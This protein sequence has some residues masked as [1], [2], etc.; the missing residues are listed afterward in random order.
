MLTLLQAVNS[1]LRN[2]GTSAVTSTEVSN[3]DVQAALNMIDEKRLSVQ[4]TGWWF[5]T[6]NNITLPLNLVNECLVPSNTLK[7][8][9]KH[10]GLDVVQQGRKLFDRGNNTFKFDQP[11][12]IGELV[13]VVDWDNLPFTA[14]EVIKFAAMHQVQSDLEGDA[15]KLQ[16]IE[17]QLNGAYL[18]MKR[19]HVQNRDVNA[20][21]SKRASRLLGRRNRS[22]RSS[23]DFLGG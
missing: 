6:Q 19:E 8:D 1:I 22:N 3:P 15:Q 21:T 4:S 9:T 12:V 13:V 16:Q 7:I 17:G 11:I 14:R 5:N 23:G 20:F 10:D 18:A 2:L